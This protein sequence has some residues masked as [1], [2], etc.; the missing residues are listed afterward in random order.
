MSWAV[1]GARPPCN[2]RGCGRQVHREVDRTSRRCRCEQAPRIRGCYDSSAVPGTANG[3]VTGQRE[4]RCHT[5][6][7]VL[8]QGLTSQPCYCPTMSPA[9]ASVC[10]MVDPAYRPPALTADVASA[11]AEARESSRCPAPPRA[12]RGLHSGFGSTLGV[13]GASP[14]ASWPMDMW[15]GVPVRVCVQLWGRW[16]VMAVLQTTGCRSEAAVPLVLRNV[17][18]FAVVM[19]VCVTPGNCERTGGVE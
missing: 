13:A 2:R 1:E 14:R 8:S 11:G 18:K 19:R 5:S 10:A 16:G 4:H 17:V 9:Y 12:S 7:Y 15:V 6:R 3:I